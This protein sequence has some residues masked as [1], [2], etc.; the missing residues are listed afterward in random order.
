M[1]PEAM[2]SPSHSTATVEQEV[3]RAH[4]LMPDVDI[5]EKDGTV[6]VLADMPGVPGAGV[7]LQMEANKL[8]LTGCATTASGESGTAAV[9]TEYHRTFTLGKDVDRDTITATR[10][11]E[12]YAWNFPGGRRPRKRKSPFQRVTARQDRQART[13]DSQNRPRFPPDHRSIT[14]SG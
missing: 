13:G 7:D 2:P 8:S 1:K 14:R 6:V 5:Y 10:A 9:R 3:I 11:K 12:S 4:R